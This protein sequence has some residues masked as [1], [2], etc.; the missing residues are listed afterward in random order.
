MLPVTLEKMGTS[1]IGSTMMNRATVARLRA[2]GGVLLFAFRGSESLITWFAPVLRVSGLR[3]LGRSEDPRSGSFP[4]QNA[5]Q[6]SK[7]ENGTLF[8]AR[9]IWQFPCKEL[10][11]SI[12]IAILL[13]TE[14]R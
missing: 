5:C 4:S 1:P 13:N 3:R 14:I 9:Y 12:D 10:L 8:R 11:L 7:V 2:P 6:S